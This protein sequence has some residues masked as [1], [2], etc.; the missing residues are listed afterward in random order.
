VHPQNGSNYYRLKSI[1]L[2]GSFKYSKV[3]LVKFGGVIQIVSS[4]SP[5]PSKGQ[6]QLKLEGRVQGKI[7]VDVVDPRENYYRVSI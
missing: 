6:L 3:V 1:D 5:N 4:I 7:T 2:D